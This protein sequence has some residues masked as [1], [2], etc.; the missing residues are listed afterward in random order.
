MAMQLVSQAIMHLHGRRG[1]LSHTY[2]DDLGG[3]EGTEQRAEEA[4]STL[5]GVM[6]DLGVVHGESKICRP[7]QFMGWLSIYFNTKETY[8]AIPHEKLEEIMTC[9]ESWRGRTRATKREMQSL[10]GLLNLWRAWPPYEVINKQ[11]VGCPQ[12]GQLDL[13]LGGSMAIQTGCH[14]PPGIYQA[15][16][17]YVRGAFGGHTNHDYFLF[18]VTGLETL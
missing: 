2:I 17:M 12:G 10:L 9:L 6:D 18:S 7:S 16:E 14:V 13:H 8:M 4:L 11:D 15:S 1:Y 5:Q 3:M